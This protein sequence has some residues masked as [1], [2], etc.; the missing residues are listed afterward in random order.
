M[1][2]EKITLKAF[3]SLLQQQENRAAE[4]SSLS[5]NLWNQWDWCDG[6]EMSKGDGMSKG[7]GCNEALASDFAVL[8]LSFVDRWGAWLLGMD[9]KVM[10]HFLFYFPM[11]IESNAAQPWVTEPCSWWNLLSQTELLFSSS[12]CLRVAMCGCE[13]W[14][15][16]GVGRPFRVCSVSKFCVYCSLCRLCL[17]PNFHG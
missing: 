16:V 1:A 11:T 7:F 13:D 15:D 14:T 5:L 4:R 10:S 3:R 2:V 6:N 8:Q 17:T 12:Q 9:G